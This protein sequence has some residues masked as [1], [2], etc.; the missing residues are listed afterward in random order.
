MMKAITSVEKLSKPVWIMGGLGLLCGVGLLDYLT[1]PELSFSLFY[2]FPIA[3]LSWATNART[4]VAISF[5]SA[6]IWFAVDVL[7][8]TRY[9]SPTIYFWNAAIRFGF[10]LLV[11]LLVQIEKTLELEKRNART[12]YLTG[13]INSRF[14]NELI[15]MEIDRSNR[16][17]HPLTIAFIDVDNFKSINDQFGHLTGDKVLETVAKSMQQHLRKTDVVARVGGDEFAILLPEADMDVAQI[18]ISKM[19]QGLLNEMRVNHWAITFSIGVMTFNT[20][21]QSADEMLNLTDKLMY[22]VKKQG[23]NNVSYAADSDQ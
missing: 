18:A 9:S 13:V 12:D 21:A 23:K 16:Y 14:F 1:G 15:Q 17:Q 19:Q 10:F 7:S 3:M 11:V 22:S 4:G 20:P 8:G 5:I 2:L 6:C